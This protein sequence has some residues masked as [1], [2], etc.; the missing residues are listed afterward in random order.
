MGFPVF[1]AIGAT[2]ALTLHH[3]LGILRIIWLPGLVQTVAYIAFMPGF[4]QA[5]SGLSAD[6]PSDTGEMVAR[7]APVALQFIVFLALSVAANVAMVSGLNR[8]IVRGESPR[9]PFYVGWGADEWR[10]LASWLIF[11]AVML[12]LEVIFIS[13]SFLGQTLRSLGP[14]PGIL[15]PIVIW[16][17]VI[18]LAVWMGVRL[19]LV[20]PATIAARRL[21]L[22]PSW[23]TSEAPFWGLFGFWA[24][25]A[26]AALIISIVLSGVFAAPGYAEAMASMKFNS[27]ESIRAAVRAANAAQMRGYDITQ[28]ANLV[29]ILAGYLLNLAGGVI[30][31]IAGAV[32]WRMASDQGEP[33]AA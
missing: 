18:C 1:K 17:A 16:I 3:G 7:F 4:L 28:G 9:L 22:A 11:G 5:V 26:V 8:L 32:A 33:A 24:L 2:F 23:S 12:G 10:L 27:P 19:S 6:P 29:R 20:A 30:I 31:A 14:G 25:F 15:L 13:A 21:G